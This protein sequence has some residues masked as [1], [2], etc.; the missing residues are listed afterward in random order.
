MKRELFLEQLPLSWKAICHWA[1]FR[2]PSVLLR[3][4]PHGLRFSCCSWVTGATRAQQYGKGSI[5][6][7]PSLTSGRRTNRLHLLC[8]PSCET[9]VGRSILGEEARAV[10]PNPQ[11]EEGMKRR[12]CGPCSQEDKEKKGEGMSRAK[13]TACTLSLGQAPRCLSRLQRASVGL[14]SVSHSRHQPQVLGALC[15]CLDL[16]EALTHVRQCW[17]WPK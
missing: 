6:C 11:P 2:W 13:G 7:H 8:L 4:R 10:L 5:C 12:L 16:D 1:V 15:S 17:A 3:Q 9:E 14:V